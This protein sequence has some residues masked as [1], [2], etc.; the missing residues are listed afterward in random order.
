M[1]GYA[2]RASRL[3]PVAATY[4]AAAAS[5]PLLFSPE[6]KKEARRAWRRREGLAVGWSHGGLA[7]AEARDHQGSPVGR[8][9]R[10]ALSSEGGPGPPKDIRQTPIS[11]M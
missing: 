11:S 2:Q 3:P 7:A 5:P 10:L 1:S 6:A 8:S 4:V 9:R